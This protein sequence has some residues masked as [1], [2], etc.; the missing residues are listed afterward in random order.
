ME[1]FAEKLDE[2]IPNTEKENFHEFLRAYTD[3]FTKN[4][5]KAKDDTF[6]NLKSIINDPNRVVISGDKDSSVVVMDKDDYVRKMTEM[7]DQGIIDGVYEETTDET[8]DDLK[9]FQDFLYRN[10]KKYE[11]YKKMYPSSH[12]PAKLYGTAKTHKFEN[13]QQI[14]VENLKFRPII[15]QT[16]TCLYSSAQVISE[17]LK[18]LYTNNEYIISNTQDFAD[19]IR[20]QPTLQQNEEYISYD[21][22][23]L[24]TNVP[25]KDTIDFI[26]NEIYTEM[27]LK[28][29]CTKLIMKRLLL[30]L[31]SES[32]FMFQSKFYKQKDGCTMGGP[33]SVTFA[34][35]YLTKLEN[36]CVKPMAPTFYKRY[37]DD[38]I[39]KRKVDTEDTLFNSIN[40]FHSKIN[41]TVE[42]NPTKFLDT[43]MVNNQGN[44][45]TKVY[46]KPNKFP[47]HWSSKTPKRYK[48]NAINGDLS[49]AYRISSDFQ[50]E[51]AVILSKFLNAGYPRLFVESTI[52]QFERKK[53]LENDDPLI[54]DWLFPETRSYCFIEIPFCIENERIAYRFL[55]KLRTFTNKEINVS[56]RWTTKKV[57]S[58]FKIKDKNP[59]PLC[60]IYKGTCSCLSTYIGET[61]RNA[62]TRWKE[63]S[64]PSSGSE[65]SK[66][67]VNHPDHEF[68]WEVLLNAPSKT[69]PRKIIEA[70]LIAI[71]KP[72]LNNQL[73]NDLILFRNGIT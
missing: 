59:H 34:N 22:E 73:D 72:D 31:S 21:V 70:F 52:R 11:K 4:I 50:H 10:F 62:E 68:K 48:R 35:I 27:K 60:C 67:L 12:Q 15:A 19:I 42:E 54:P 69:R 16:G 13:N 7:I 58:L 9:H 61:N 45:V 44:I 36:E 32:T 29:I 37:V 51:K 14:T 25:I 18:P 46:R 65:P 63:H 30:K 1:H 47:A 39:S 33:L 20:A 64:K 3:I 38:V 26:I 23:S 41:F 6:K 43:T 56:I 8:L 24:F 71:N 5:Y 2:S 40:N 55:S 53:N 66:H 17:Y 49:R 57:K 28:P